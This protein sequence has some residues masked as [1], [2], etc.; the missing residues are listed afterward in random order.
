VLSQ[1]RTARECGNS[2]QGGEGLKLGR[3]GLGSLTHGRGGGSGI[4]SG[5]PFVCT[6]SSS[7]RRKRKEKE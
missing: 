1:E 4:D 7:R 5:R 2:L 3:V 6:S